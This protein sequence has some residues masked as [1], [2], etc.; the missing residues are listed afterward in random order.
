MSGLRFGTAAKLYSDARGQALPAQLDLLNM[1]FPSLIMEELPSDG[2][3]KT[4]AEYIDRVFRIRAVNYR[5]SFYAGPS[6]RVS[7][8]TGRLIGTA[9]G[10]QE[11]ERRTAF[12]IQKH[13][14][15]VLTTDFETT[16]SLQENVLLHIEQLKEEERE[17]FY[18]FILAY[19]EE[20]LEERE[21]K[22]E[23]ELLCEPFPMDREV[24]EGILYNAVYQ[25]VKQTDQSVANSFLWLLLGGLLRNEAGRVLRMFDSSFVP[26]GRQTSENG[27]LRDRLMYL[28]EPECYESFYEGDDLDKRFPGI[29]WFCDRCGDHLNE[30]EGFTDEAPVWICRNCGYENRIDADVIFASREDYHNQIRPLGEDALQRA[31][32]ERKNRKR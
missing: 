30:Q 21:R 19:I 6:R 4:E 2:S 13:L 22:Q 7:Q 23:Y 27:T 3:T 8:I 31:V 14:A 18:G 1:W 25:L 10:N 17:R 5:G 24:F 9:N 16:A 29:E 11:K 15:E 28:I 20:Q 32:S 26:I 12:L